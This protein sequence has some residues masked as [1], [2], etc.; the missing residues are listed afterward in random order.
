M[1]VI[2]T[3]TGCANPVYNFFEDKHLGSMV[4]GHSLY[5]SKDFENLHSYGDIGLYIYNHV[6][7]DYGDDPTVW[8]NPET[9]LATGKGSCA[10]MAVLYLDI[11]HYVLHEDGE[12]VC[13]DTANISRSVESGGYVNHAQVRFGSTIIEPFTGKQVSVSSIGYSYSFDNIF[14][15]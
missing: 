6:S 15:K 9:T 10:D 14:D 11:A 5:Y 4:G 13:I 8:N 1:A 12:I 3:L 2:L 7:Y